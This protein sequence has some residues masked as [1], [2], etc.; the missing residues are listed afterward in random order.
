MTKKAL[1]S[2]RV[3]PQKEEAMT[4]PV[5]KAPTEQ[6]E[7]EIDPTIVKAWEVATKEC[8]TWYFVKKTCSEVLF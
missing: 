6:T 4:P 3:K 8:E 1:A 2:R 7:K 5:A